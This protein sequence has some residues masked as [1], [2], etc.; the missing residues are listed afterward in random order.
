MN[1]ICVCEPQT[2]GPR[3][4][5]EAVELAIAKHTPVWIGTG[6]SQNCPH[7]HLRL[8]AHLCELVVGNYN[9][10]LGSM[11]IVWCGVLYM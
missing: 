3:G 6:E 7:F 2:L 11:C 4:V 10:H 9:R 1:V 5:A 8:V